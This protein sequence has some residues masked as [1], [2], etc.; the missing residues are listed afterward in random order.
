[1]APRRG[2]LVLCGCSRCLHSDP[3]GRLIR[4]SDRRQHLDRD[5]ERELRRSAG[6]SRAPPPPPPVSPAREPSLPFRTPSPIPADP[7]RSRSNEADP[8]PNPGGDANEGERPDDGP[9]DE[10]PDAPIHGVRTESEELPWLRLFLL[11]LLWL[12]CAR[13]LSKACAHIILSFLSNLV[14]PV[15]NISAPRHFAT[16]RKHLGHQSSLR[17]FAICPNFDCQ[18][19]WSIDLAPSTCPLCNTAVFAPDSTSKPMQYFHYGSVIGFLQGCFE[20]PQF[21]TIINHWRTRTNRSTLSDIYDGTAWDTNGFMGNRLHLYLSIGVDWFVPYTFANTASYTIG[22]VSVRIENLPHSMRNQPEFM[23]VAAILPG[24]RQ[25][26]DAGLVAALRP[27]IDELRR[28]NDGVEVDIPGFPLSRTVKAR[29]L[30]AL[31]D[32]PARAKLAGFPSHTQHGQWCGYCHADSHTWVDSLIRQETPDPRDPDTHRNAAFVVKANPAAR[33][34]TIRTNGATWTALYDLPYWSF[35]IIS[36]VIKS[37][38]YPRN[39]TAIRPNFGTTRGGSPTSDQWSTFSRF[40]LPLVLASHWADLLDVDG[41]RE[42]SVRHKAFRLPGQAQGTPSPLFIKNVQVRHLIRMSADLSIITH[43]V[44]CRELTE[45]R[46]QLLERLIRD[47]ISA[48]ATHIDPRWMVPNHHA[49]THLP[50]HIRRFGPPRAFWFYSMERLNGFLKKTVHNEH[51]GGELE[52]SMQANHALFRSVRRQIRALGDSDEEKIFRRLLVDEDAQLDPFE[53]SHADSLQPQVIGK[54]ESTL[55]EP[56]VVNA[57]VQMVNSTRGSADPLAAPELMFEGQDRANHI[58]ITSTAT[59]FPHML[60]KSVKVSPMRF[61]SNVVKGAPNIIVNSNTGRRP[62][63]LVSVF[64]HTYS[65]PQRGHLVKRIY[66]EVEMYT[67]VEWPRNH[68]LASSAPRL[69]YHLFSSLNP[70]PGVVPIDNIMDTYVGATAGY[71]TRNETD[72]FAAESHPL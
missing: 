64:E 11:L 54:G 56:T 46:L 35:P 16:V 6:P 52:Y 26:S 18:T 28:L 3:T 7:N 69:G 17:K 2:N 66:A 9:D 33:D 13:G 50:E 62:A 61:R 71:I 31:G 20:D 12:S 70:Q 40:L 24:P 19:C 10:V 22:A 63:R 39:L 48:T 43:L 59:R 36:E 25:T 29:V 55:L 5:L 45:D 53:V 27:L 38:T 14:L 42:F 44:Q 34:E 15:Y 58:L 41:H 23:H 68:A 21:E 30:L 37:A 67:A 72:M 8:N 57:I 49:M 51:H 32:M 60:V 4:S 65:N 47:H 1:M